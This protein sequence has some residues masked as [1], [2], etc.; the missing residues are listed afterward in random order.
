MAMLR[1][2]LTH[3]VKLKGWLMT[4]VRLKPMVTRRGLLN[5]MAIMKDLHLSLVILIPMD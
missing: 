4:R 3:L 2:K 5:S 1:A